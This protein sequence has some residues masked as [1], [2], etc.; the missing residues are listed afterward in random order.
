MTT[1]EHKSRFQWRQAPPSTSRSR[2]GEFPTPGDVL[3][4]AAARNL[5]PTDPFKPR[6]STNGFTYYLEKVRKVVIV[7]IT[8]KLESLWVTVECSSLQILEDLWDDYCRKYLR[9]FAQN[10]LVSKDILEELGLTNVELRT[11]ISENE[12]KDCRVQFLQSLGEYECLF[13][14]WCEQ[15]NKQEKTIFPDLEGLCC[16]IVHLLSCYLISSET[17]PIRSTDLICIWEMHLYSVF[18]NL[19]I[20][21]FVEVV[22]PPFSWDKVVH[23]GTSLRAIV[24][25]A[26]VFLLFVFT[27]QAYNLS[28]IENVS[29]KV[30]QCK[31]IKQ[32]ISE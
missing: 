10:T 28:K 2:K 12:Y 13:H 19:N 29:I 31:A 32:I 5:H 7:D 21:I 3:K 26:S 11:T 4:L 15:E 22:K 23:E 27:T 6:D 24:V 14:P 9:G 16:F 25:N 17:K 30:N 1:Q 8:Q 18:I 20:G